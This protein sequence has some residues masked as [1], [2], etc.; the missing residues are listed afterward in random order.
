MHFAMCIECAAHK[1]I[2]CD[3]LFFG[4]WVCVCVCPIVGCLDSLIWKLLT[5]EIVTEKIAH[6]FCE[7][8]KTY[9]YDVK[10]GTEMRIASIRLRKKKP[11]KWIELKEI[12][13]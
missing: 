5:W 7:R 13:K 10:H 6:N 1:K 8:L 3:V 4:E 11:F 2:V 12:H 9:F